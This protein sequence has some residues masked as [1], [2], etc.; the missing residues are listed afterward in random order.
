[1]DFVPDYVRKVTDNLLSNAF[2]FTPEY[3]RI[4][5]NMWQK[6][7]RLF[8]DV[9]DTGAG[10]DDDTLTHIFEPFYQAESDTKHIGTG[11]GLALVKQII[12]SVRGSII[13]ES[14]LGK[15]TTF[16]LSITR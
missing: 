6:G 4:S 3:G 10:M 5:V 16:H 9:A 11:V 14:A 7:E 12:D 1:M 15:G 8:I 2:K 13:V